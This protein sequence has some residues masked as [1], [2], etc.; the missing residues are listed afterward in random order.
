M[1][2]LV[3]GRVGS[4]SSTRYASLTADVECPARTFG[5][6]DGLET[7]ARMA[8]VTGSIATTAPR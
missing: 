8:P 1:A 6:Y 7:M 2:R 3:S 4:S 5:S